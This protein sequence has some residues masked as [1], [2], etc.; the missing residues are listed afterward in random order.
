MQ[1]LLQLKAVHGRSKSYVTLMD[2]MCTLLCRVTSTKEAAFLAV[3]EWNVF[4]ALHIYLPTPLS[5]MLQEEEEK[6]SQG[7][8]DGA[9]HLHEP[10]LLRDDIRVYKI[11]LRNLPASYF[12]LL[13]GLC[14]VD[15]A[16][17]I[18]LT[19]GYLRRALEKFA[20]HYSTLLAADFKPARVEKWEAIRMELV[21]SLKFLSICANHT[22]VQKGSANDLILSRYFHVEEMCKGIILA[23]ED[24]LRTDELVHWCYQLLASL[25]QDTHR[26]LT[27]IEANDLFSV[28]RDE[29][30][31]FLDIPLRT[32]GSLVSLLRH[33]TQGI[34]SNYLHA[35]IPQL[36]EP[37]AKIARIYPALAFKVDEA[38]WN[39]TRSM[40]MY[41]KFVN[42]ESSK[43]FEKLRLEEFIRTGKL[44]NDINDII[45]S[46][47][48]KASNGQILE[49]DTSASQSAITP[50][51]P[52]SGK[53]TNVGTFVHC[54]ITSC[55][56]LGYRDQPE[57]H[58]KLA[59]LTDEERAV[60]EADL[61]KVTSPISKRVSFSPIKTTS[62]VKRSGKN[63]QNN[64]GDRSF[65]KSS[66]PSIK[67]I[68][69]T[70]VPELIL[71]RPS[72]S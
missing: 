14:K 23:R 3:N 62:S 60:R 55:G 51:L 27:I 21:A 15:Q 37:L 10:D 11:G 36:R 45:G 4:K 38:N 41:R 32:A 68:L 40:M 44:A 34:T 29:I 6:L 22:A 5:G 65:E 28:V 9:D 8:T 48:D 31:L 61:L 57:G 13:A 43:D 49:V 56:S 30:L 70:D 7:K 67:T 53:A 39:M 18:C 42:E 35:M 33:A 26:V 20:M 17:S 59:H 66:L 1:L 69:L 47:G 24:I 16:R 72:K 19:D 52:S 25:S 54:G 46:I 50:A 63:F 64:Y 2:S 12:E 58:G 71:T